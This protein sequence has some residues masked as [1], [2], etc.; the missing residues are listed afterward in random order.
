[1]E[2]DADW[3][4][5]NDWPGKTLTIGDVRLAVLLAVPRCVIT[6]LRQGDLPADR[7]VLRTISQH[8]SLDLGVGM[9]PCLG[10]YA[11]VTSGGEISV[12]D[13]VTVV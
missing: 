9:L 6:T 3:F 12:H 2:T 7:E 4:V 8:N 5:E 10:V 11:D 1:V 13:L